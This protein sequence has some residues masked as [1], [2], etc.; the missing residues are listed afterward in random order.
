[1]KL[2]R[3]PVLLRWTHI[4]K[5]DVIKENS[6]PPQEE[7]KGYFYICSVNR[8]FRLIVDSFSPA[9]LPSVENTKPATIGELLQA[10]AQ[11][12]HTQT[13]RRILMWTL[14]M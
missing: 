13:S 1:M 6:Y 4:F 2:N 10:T 3:S 7:N 12:T 8:T 5:D 9:L 11:E 14:K